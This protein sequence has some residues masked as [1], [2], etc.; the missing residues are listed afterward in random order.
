[1]NRRVLESLL[2]LDTSSDPVTIGKLL[3]SGYDV[4]TETDYS[5]LQWFSSQSSRERSGVVRTSD[6]TVCDLDI[7]HPTGSIQATP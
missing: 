7:V 1:M 5:C 6:I 3:V 2:K 4:K